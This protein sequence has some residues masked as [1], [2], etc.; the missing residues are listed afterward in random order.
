MIQNETATNFILDSVSEVQ[1]IEMP[2]RG[3]NSWK[4]QCNYYA[5]IIT[6][7]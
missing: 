1:A 5:F 3:V 4:I 2:P 6:A 7:T